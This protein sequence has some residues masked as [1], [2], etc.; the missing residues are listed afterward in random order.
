[1]TKDSPSD[2][3]KVLDA[4]LIVRG[5]EIKAVA[6]TTPLLLPRRRELHVSKAIG[7]VCIEHYFLNSLTKLVCFTGSTEKKAHREAERKTQGVR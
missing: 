4:F 5:T 7:R 1:M 3:V 2:H 6:I